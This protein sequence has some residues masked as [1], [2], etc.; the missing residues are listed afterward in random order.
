MAK[1]VSLNYSGFPGFNEP[2]VASLERMI[3]QVIGQNVAPTPF[4]N[5]FVTFGSSTMA[6]TFDYTSFS[7]GSQP[8]SAKG[9]FNWANFFLDQR[10]ILLRGAGKTS[11]TLRDMLD[12]LKRDVLDIAPAW[13]L[14]HIASNDL[15]THGRD[16]ETAFRWSLNLVEPCLG[17]GINVVW[18]IPQPRTTA[19]SSYSTAKA[20]EYLKYCDAVRE[21]C[22]VNPNVICLDTARLVTDPATGNAITNYY[23]DTLHLSNLGAF[24]VGEELAN[25]LRPLIPAVSTT[26]LASNHSSTSFTGSNQLWPDPF[27]LTTGG[28]LQTGCTGTLPDGV[29]AFRGVGGAGTTCACSIVPAPSVNGLPSRGNAMRFDITFAAQTDRISVAYA[30]ATLRPKL[31]PGDRVVFEGRMKVY[32]G[33]TL[34]AI[35]SFISNNYSTFMQDMARDITATG[36]KPLPN[37]DFMGMFRTPVYT[38][39][40]AGVTNFEV[41][42]GFLAD[43]AGTARIDVFEIS[44]RKVSSQ[45]PSITIA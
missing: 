9:V 17:Q 15:W 7:N 4:G 14:M 39:P 33:N 13:V 3:Q 25:M 1:K 35:P 18:M 5:T 20:T 37:R 44:V 32:A 11:E 19:D 40:A 16:A 31:S 42:H 6:N 2:Q 28:T 36:D 41:N 23:S 10:L 26:P 43:G 30:D 45:F 38:V 24:I 12:R 29:R 21:Y 8:K 27:F 34:R 22:L